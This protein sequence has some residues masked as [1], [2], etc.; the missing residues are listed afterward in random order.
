MNTINMNQTLRAFW[1]ASRMP[2]Q[3]PHPVFFDYPE[4]QQTAHTLNRYIGMKASGVLTGPNGCGKSMLLDHVLHELPEQ[5]FCVIRLSHTTLTGS[6]MIRRLCRLNGLCASIRRSDNI[7]QL[8]E[9]WTADGRTP[10]LAIDEAQNLNPATLEELRLLNCE[11]TRTCGREEA[12]PFALL[13][14]G[15]DD[16]M[17]TIDLNIHRALR[18]RLTFHARLRPLTLQDTENYCVFQWKQVG[19]QSSPFDVQ[20]INLLH[21]ASEGLPRTINQI[22]LNAIFDALDKQQKIITVENVQAALSI[23]P[24]IGK[25]SR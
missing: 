21:T 20:T 1:G 6:D 16:L 24:W 10:V 22:A 9:F 25:H 3:E 13:L 18:S 17:P 4:L 15:D 19:V 5:Q 7:Q 11:R 14:C 2:F 8:L 12:S 23:T